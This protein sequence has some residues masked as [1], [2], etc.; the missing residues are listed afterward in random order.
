MAYRCSCFCLWQETEP[1]S[2]LCL[3]KRKSRN[4]WR[5]WGSRAA[6][7]MVLMMSL[8]VSLDEAS[9]S[10][11][12]RHYLDWKMKWTSLIMSP[13]VKVTV[14]CDVSVCRYL[15]MRN[16][17][18]SL[19]RCLSG[20]HVLCGLVYIVS[21]LIFKFMAIVDPPLRATEAQQPVWGGH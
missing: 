17:C 3:E 20:R 7:V 8:L 11:F 10:Y 16:I 21:V 2:N 6:C 18:C 13:V 15:L 1:S 12:C 9:W 5:Y 14:I 19:R 4:D